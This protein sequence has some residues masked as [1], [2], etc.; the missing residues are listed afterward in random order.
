MKSYSDRKLE[1]W[2]NNYKILIILII[3]KGTMIN[4]D[5]KGITYDEIFIKTDN[6]WN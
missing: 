6:P 3:I 5:D 1:L 2:S 4:I